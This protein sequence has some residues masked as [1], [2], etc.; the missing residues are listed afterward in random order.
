MARIFWIPGNPRPPLATLL[1]PRGGRELY[2]QM[3]EI[4]RAGIQ[5]LVSLLEEEQV[6]ILDLADEGRLASSMGMQFI[7]HP[8]PDHSLPPDEAAFRAF[9]SGLANRLRDGERVGIHCWGSIGRATM[10]AA[11]ALI[12]L[13]WDPHAALVA[14]ETARCCPVPDTAEQEEWI[15]NYKEVAAIPQPIRRPAPISA[16][17]GA[18]MPEPTV[19]LTF[20]HAWRA[21]IL[22]DTP[23]TLPARQFIYPP[24]AEEV[25]Q[26]ALEVLIRSTAQGAQ[27]FLATCALGFSDPAVPSGIWSAPRRDEICLVSGGYAYVIDTA[28]PENFTMI[29]FR[30]VMEIRP[31]V[32]Q[33]LLLFI[34]SQGILGWGADGQAWVSEKLSDEGIKITDIAGGILHGT[35][36][37]MKTDRETPFALDLMTGVRIPARE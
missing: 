32:A 20:P 4:Q 9:V 23:T 1:C 19:D 13:G 5:T 18:T 12:H 3:R 31:V 35:G 34:D 33:G 26:G 2:D 36:W 37:D 11:C 14:I 7:F 6:D 8:L 28:A 30:P 24:E 29:P 17:I 10:V 25:E 27:P 16:P 22:A 15:L 21:N